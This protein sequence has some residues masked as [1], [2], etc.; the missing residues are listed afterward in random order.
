MREE[1]GLAPG[2]RL[3]LVPSTKQLTAPGWRALERFALNGMFGVGH[4][5]SYGLVDPIKDV[6]R[7]RCCR[8][9]RAARSGPGRW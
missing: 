6:A 5:L 8:A 2:R 1:D 7:G 9:G 3:Y 4:Q